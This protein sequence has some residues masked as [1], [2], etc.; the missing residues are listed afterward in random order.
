MHG[1]IMR[2][3]GYTSGIMVRREGVIVL[4]ADVCRRIVRAMRALSSTRE[5]AAAR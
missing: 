2:S 1:E 4:D 5:A 3:L